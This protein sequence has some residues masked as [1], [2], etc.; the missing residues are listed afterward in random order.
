MSKNNSPYPSIN[1]NGTPMLSNSGIDIKGNP[2]GITDSLE[3][4]TCSG[5]VMDCNSLD[6]GDSI[7]CDDSIDFGCDIGC[8]FSSDFGSDF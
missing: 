4:D 5:L 1:T 3:V 2:Y 8:D 7:S 6:M